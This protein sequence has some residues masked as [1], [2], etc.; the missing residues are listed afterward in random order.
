MGN[1]LTAD[2]WI[3]AVPNGDKPMVVDLASTIKLICGSEDEKT[4]IFSAKH[5]I[6]ANEKH[7]SSSIL[8]PTSIGL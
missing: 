6:S 8:F 2:N 4:L 1:K 5:K 7:V 3:I